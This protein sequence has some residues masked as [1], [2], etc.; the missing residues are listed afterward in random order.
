[1]IYLSAVIITKNEEKNIERCIKSLLLVADEI[2]VVDSFSTDSTEEICKHYNVRF[3]KHAFEG[4]IQQ[5]NWALENAS[6]EHVLSL[7][8]DEALSD[9]LRNEIIK[10]KENWNF[11]GYSFNRLNNYCGKW[12]WHSGWYPDTKIRLFKR[13][14]ARWGGVNPHDIIEMKKGAT[15]KHIKANLLHYSFYTISQHI[16]QIDS[17]STIAA[18]ERFKRG[19]KASVAKILFATGMKFI[20]HYIF[21]RGF[22][23]GFAG[24][25]I[26]VNSA[27]AVFLRY[28]K[29]R[30]LHKS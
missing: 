10:I 3:L 29:L 24:L 2:L 6:Y 27:H 30:M 13:S 21:K 9:E 23:D 17:F 11:D 7:D 19:L 25:I 28:V 15:V 1:M 26:S 12:I 22:L 8:A 4:H 14:V 16:Q 18:E 5:K 20:K